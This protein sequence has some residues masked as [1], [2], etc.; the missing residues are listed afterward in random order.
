MRPLWCNSLLAAALALASTQTPGFRIHYQLRV[1]QRAGGE[2]RLLASGE[3]SGPQD[4]D[5]RL[6][7]RTD[8]LTVETL[9]ELFPEPDTVN[10]TATFFTRRRTGRSRRGLSLWEEDSYRRTARLAWGGTARLYPFGAGR[11]GAARP[12][13][14]EITLTR[15]PAAG[16]TRPAEAMAVNDSTLGVSLE[17]VVRPRRARVTLTLVRGDSASAPKSLDLVPDAPGRRVTFVLGPGRERALDVGLVRPEPP[18]TG[19]DSALA[20]DAEVVCLRVTLPP[21]EAAS[22]A[23]MRCGRLNNVARRLPLSERDTLVA[24]FA[25]PAVR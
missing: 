4:T 6:S 21:P 17:A 10:L 23:R 19:R 9:L 3:V 7:L 13:W 14:V 25:W 22:P 15:A 16:E 18:T 8:S 24:I 12:L 20:L 2:A 1:L 5:V 11:A